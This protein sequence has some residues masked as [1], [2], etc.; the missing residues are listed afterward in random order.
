M[1]IYEVL[2]RDH[3]HVEHLFKRIAKGLEKK[4]FSEVPEL[5]DELKT[6]LTA[7]SK[8]EQEVFY[9]PLKILAGN[10]DGKDLSWEGE[11]E[12]HVIRLLLSELSRV[13]FH[14]EEWSAKLKVLGEV[15]SHHVEEEEQEIFKVGRKV[16]SE[17]DAERIAEDMESL[18]AQYK[19]LIDET[20]NEDVQILLRPIT[21]NSYRANT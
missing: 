11:E 10:K 12:H 6:E 1:T 14:S 19:S 3:R 15:V 21:H 17:D 18:K 4:D 2:K 5:F 16:F 7:H 20:L 9:Q 13:P 8:A